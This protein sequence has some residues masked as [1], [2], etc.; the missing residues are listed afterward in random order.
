VCQRRRGHATGSAAQQRD[1]ADKRR[2]V[3]PFGR[4]FVRRRLQLIP[5]FDGRQGGKAR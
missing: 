3:A 1:A 5:V 4:I 2:V